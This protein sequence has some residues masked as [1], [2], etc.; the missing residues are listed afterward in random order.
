MR[1]NDSNVH[2]NLRPIQAPVKQV[3][4]VEDVDGQPANGEQSHNNGEG[5]GGPYLLLQKPVVMAVPVANTLELDLSQLLPGHREDLQVDAQHDEQ[6]WQ[7]AHKEVKIN[8]VPHVHHTLK[9]A[10]EHAPVYRVSSAPR[11][12]SEANVCSVVLTRGGVITF[13]VQVPAKERDEANDK[14]EDP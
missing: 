2:N 5:F 8:H 13:C 6:G 7:H 4:T 11:P 3:E 9:E 12:L 10:P 1:Q 14:G